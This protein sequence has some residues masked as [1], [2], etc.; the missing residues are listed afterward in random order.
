VNDTDAHLVGITLVVATVIGLAGG[1]WL[2]RWLGYYMATIHVD[3]Q[4]ARRV[5]TFTAKNIGQRVDVRFN[6]TRLA[7]PKI[8]DPLPSGQIPTSLNGWTRAQIE[9]VFARY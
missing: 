4:A 6:G 3:A 7:V 9:Q 2:D 5:H 1:Y 8:L